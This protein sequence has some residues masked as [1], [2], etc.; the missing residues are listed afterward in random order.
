MKNKII[1]KIG[2]RVK[3][4]HEIINTIDSECHG[5]GTI[6][7]YFKDGLFDETAEIVGLWVKFDTGVERWNYFD[8]FDLI[9]NESI[10]EEDA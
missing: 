7:R 9:P 6:T 10:F 3:H 1:F 2:D 4:K 8:K 5:E